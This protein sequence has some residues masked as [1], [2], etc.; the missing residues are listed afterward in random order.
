MRVKEHFVDFCVVGGGMAGVCAALAAARHGVKVLLMQDR[1]VLGGNASSEIRMWICGANGSDNK[2][3]GILEELELENFYRNNPPNYHI[4]DSVL[5]GKIKEEKNISLLLN[6]SCF[7]AEMGKSKIVSVTG[8]QTTTQTRHVVY[9]RYFADC[10]GDSVLAPLV[11]ADYRVGRES[12]SEFGESIQPDV[13][14]SKTMGNSILFQIRE[15]DRRSSFIP[16][17]FACKYETDDDLPYRDHGIGSNFWWIELGG[18]EDTIYDAESIKDELLKVAFGVWDHMKNH[19]DHGVDNHV[20]DWIGFLPGK[21]ESRRYVGDYILT[22]NDIEAGG[23]FHD[24]VG[25]GGWTMDD[26]P[27]AGFK[28]KGLPTNHYPAPSPYGIP[29]RVLYSRNIENLF[30]AGRNISVTHAALSSTRV[31]GTCS[32]LGQA[33]GTAVYLGVREN[34]NPREIG[35]KKIRELQELLMFD[36]CFLPFIKREVTTLTK[37]ATIDERYENLRNGYDR[38]IMN[39]DNGVYLNPGD[40]IEFKYSDYVKVQGLRIIFDSNLNR[41]YHNMPCYYPLKNKESYVPETLVKKFT[42]SAITPEGEKV[43]HEET[44]NYQRFVLLKFDEMVQTI[45]ITPHET[46]GVE[47]AH[48]FSVDVI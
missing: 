17:S 47:K 27:P 8:W 46:W 23:I 19:G 11:N 2:E 32:V 29:Y 7:D 21:R 43:L 44:C 4:W 26:H 12:E 25:Y 42:V 16:P 6:C 3:T 22:Q 10:S 28:H 34:L 40:F 36:D 14:D 33:V 30:F 15:T 45:R 9:A 31:M 37:Q 1:P 38:P 39:V 24:I 13:A 20:L 18:E 5:Y 35:E 41:P 48:I